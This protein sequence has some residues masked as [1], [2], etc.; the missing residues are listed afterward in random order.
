MR[1]ALAALAFLLAAGPVL[2]QDGLP[3]FGYVGAARLRAEKFLLPSPRAAAGDVIAQDSLLVQA[4]TK[5][6]IGFASTPAEFRAAAA[7]WT[8]AL[9]AA[10]VTA[11]TPAFA[12]GMYTIPY[13]TADGSGVRAFLAD[14]KQFPPKDEAGLRANMALAEAALAKA[15][16]PLVAARVVRVDALLPTYLILY[17]TKPDANPDREVRLRVLKPGDDMDFDAFRKAG[18][19]VVQTPTTWMMVYLG[20]AVGYVGLAAKSPKDLDAKVAAREDFFRQNGERLI[21]VRKFAIDDPEWKYGA[22]LYFFQ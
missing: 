5:A 1:I 14:P 11:G 6:L 16:L 19:D 15:G 4:G 12:D 21:A 17:R 22:G 20:P 8:Q 13:A 18:V 7:Y 10:G 3:A 2:A 9:A